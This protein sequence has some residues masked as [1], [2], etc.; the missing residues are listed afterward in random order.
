MRRTDLETVDVLGVAFPKPSRTLGRVARGLAGLALLPLEGIPGRGPRRAVWS[1]PGRLYI[2]THGVKGPDGARVARRVERALAEIPGVRWAQVNAPTSR[3]VVAVG[4]PQPRRLELIRAVERAEAEPAS[5]AERVEEEELH[6]PADGTTATRL[7]STLAADAA[8]L[9]L[10]VASKVMPWAPLPTEVAA[11]ASLVDLHPRLRDLADRK[12]RGRE[13]ADSATSIGAALVHGLAARSEGTVLDILVRGTQWREAKAHQR[14]WCEAES[15]L[16]G[17]R[18]HAGADSVVSE[19]PWPLPESAADRHAR[20]SIAAGAAAAAAALPFVGPRRAAAVGISALPKAPSNGAA[21]FSAQLGQVLA[22]RGALVMDRSA[23]RRLDLLDT[24]V[25]DTTALGAGANVLSDLV[26]LPEGDQVDLT[27]AAFALFDP[28][29]PEVVRRDGEWTLGPVDEL[30]VT[31][32]PDRQRM[33]DQGAHLVLGLVRDG[34]PAGLLAV[35]QERSPDVDALASAAEAAG[36]RVVQTDGGVVLDAVRELQAC[37]RVV[38]LVSDDR[39][40]LGASDCGVGVHEDGTPPPWG[41]HVLIGRDVDTAVLLVEASTA[42]KAVVRDSTMFA[43]AASGIGGVTALSSRRRPA[44]SG[45][46]AVNA[47]ALMAFGD[48]IWRARTLTGERKTASAGRVVPPWHLMP[49]DLVLDRLGSGP[50]GLDEREARRRAPADRAGGEGNAGTSIAKA[51]MAELANPLTPVLAGGAAVS[52]AVGSPVDAALVAGIVGV[53]ALIGSAQQV[54]TDRALAGLFERSATVTTVLRDGAERQI[55]ADSL[56]RGDVVSLRSGDVVP[57]DCRVLEATGA[58]LDESSLTGESLPVPKT[59]APVVAAEIAER[60]SMLYEGTTVAAGKVSAVVVATGDETEVGRGLA[61]ARGAAPETGV[62]AR[63]ASLTK[64][65]L[66]VAVGSA[67]AVAGAGLIRGVPLRQSVGAAVN[68]AVASVP[69]GLPFLV[70]AAQLAA[71]RRLA[72]HGALVRN[73]RTIEALGRV[74]VLCF[75]KTGTLTEGKLSVS[76]IDDGK[77]TASVS[78]LRKSHQAVLAAAVRATPRAENPE[79]LPHHTDQAVLEG[80]ITAGV[81]AGGWEKTNA[82]PFEPSRGFHAT[83]GKLGGRHVVCVKGAPETVLPLCT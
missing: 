57:A 68:L 12:L 64:Q 59:P 49:P 47:G 40:A 5:E 31:G 33:L 25:I 58:E 30:D 73:P 72:E 80:G 20:R 77:T 81:D 67:A 39:R 7:P 42:A 10:S 79:E 50:R 56:V 41:A 78:R 65:A 51:F 35:A 2:E 63:L 17:Q 23:L 22:R 18:E 75:D 24:I 76:R 74:D 82:V 29:K 32:F 21:A 54:H 48:G 19:R 45:L 60:S 4:D 13:R 53:S 27:A 83:N 44:A 15:K 37:G 16:V 3:V 69:E 11:L 36:M 6:H 52:A 61:A 34:R 70:N 28:E 26:P 71:A 46:R 66:P 8:G 1:C 14:A 55:V 9:M 62:E 43:T 38:M